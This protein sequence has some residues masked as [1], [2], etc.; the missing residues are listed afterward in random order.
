MRTIGTRF[1]PLFL[2]IVSCVFSGCAVSTSGNLLGEAAATR[3]STTEKKFRFVETGMTF[4][5]AGVDRYVS[6]VQHDVVISGGSISLKASLV[7]LNYS[8]L[9]QKGGMFLSVPL[10]IPLDIGIRPSI[11][12][13]IGPFYF[14]AGVSLVGGFYPNEQDD[15]YEPEADDSFGRFDGF[16]LYNLG[17]GAMLDVGK[18]LTVGAYANY[19]RMAMNC[20]GA[21][22]ANYGFYLDILDDTRGK[23]N[24]PAYA[25]RANVMT[26]GVN[27]FIKM[28]NPLGFYAEYSPGT[29]MKNDGWWKF[30]AGGVLLY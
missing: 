20:G 8:L 5:S 13:W 18:S 27:A 24:L 15:G 30:R 1:L 7:S 9:G 6:S 19:E 29:L 12:Q 3:F 16:I 22:V 10:T 28:K 4:A 21:V 2:G 14:G 26:L 25:R 17:G 23:E 11:V